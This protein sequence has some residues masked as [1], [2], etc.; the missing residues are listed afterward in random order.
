MSKSKMMFKELF[1][2]VK[3]KPEA[4]ASF[5]AVLELVKLKKIRVEYGEE[6]DFSNPHI[7]RNDNDVDLSS[8]ED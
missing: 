1:K 5:L 7:Y 6:N 2:G 4:V 8:I 3:S